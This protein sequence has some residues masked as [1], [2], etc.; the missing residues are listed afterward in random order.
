MSVSRLLAFA[1]VLAVSGAAAAQGQPDYGTSGFLGR[2]SSG[3]TEVDRCQASAELAEAERTARAADH[4]DR[5]LVLYEQ[6][7]YAGAVE[8]FV[9]SYCDK[10]HPSAFYN[11]AQSY[12][13]LLDYEKALAYFERYILESD[14]DAPNRKKA[15]LRAEVLA[16]T[17]AQVRVATVPAGATVTLRSETGVTA[18][19]EANADEPLLV[20][21]GRYTMQVQMPGYAPVTE[22]IV[23]RIGQPYSYYFRLEPEKG[24]VRIVAEP[25]RARIFFDKRLVGVGSYV[26]TVPVG[27]YQVVVEA[28]GRRSEQHAVAVTADETSSLSV[29][30]EA[31]PES[32]R[33]AL[34][35]SSSLGLGLA[36]S[37]SLGAVFD[38]GSGLTTVGG[39]LGLGIGWSGAYF[40][41][42]D[43]IPRPQ[44]WHIIGSSIAGVA[45]GAIVTAYLS[46]DTEEDETGTTVSSCS[47]DAIAA[48][49][50]AGGIGGMLFG[51][52]TAGPID[53][54]AGD[55]A[56]VDSAAV[57]GLATS[58]IVLA[59]FDTDARIREPVLFAGLNLGLAAGVT[60]ASRS[61]VSLRRVALIDLSGLGGLVG[62]FA[63]AQAFDA[64]GERIEHASLL[65]MATGLVAGTLL[66]RTLDEPD[67]DVGTLT[68]ATGAVKDAS[69]QTALTLG[70][71]LRF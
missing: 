13:R 59:I 15:A 21:Q 26:E 33:T 37:I 25:P 60:L 11:I 30:L 5:G 53:P 66:T 62:G 56:L 49:A 24:V 9:A 32:G 20:R 58:G 35:W 71:R 44:A 48:G 61:D 39:L 67:A 52:L 36:G 54:D 1:F 3:T 40:G 22:E 28:E 12:E 46:C 16:N 45:E 65:G 69:G 14:A 8:E 50:L 55:L 68:P 64:P 41:V 57:W 7:D 2:I 47:N 38:E 70:A 23:V 19:A 51:A 42:P 34:I 29:A 10:S 43:D 4:Y 63:L 6:G 17:P 27:N 18:R 31:P